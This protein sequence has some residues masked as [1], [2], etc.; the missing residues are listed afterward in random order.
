MAQ[1]KTQPTKVD[2]EAFLAAVEPPARQ[3]DG[4]MLCEIMGRI[5]GDA[6]R[7]WGPTIVG[8][9]TYHYRYE[10]GREGDSLRVGFSPRKPA[11]VLYIAG[12]FPRY[13]GLLAQLGPHTTGKACLYIKRLSDID[14]NV[15][16]ELIA[17]SLI[18]MRTAY[19]D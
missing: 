6:P 10:S 13:E 8:F 17:E 3:A 15:L 14:L 7:L 18:Y 9:G 19:P 16:E 12:G 4:R 5:S 2:V 11:L 1:N